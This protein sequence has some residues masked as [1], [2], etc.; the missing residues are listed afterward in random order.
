MR[1]PLAELLSG[2]PWPR[3]SGARRLIKGLDACLPVQHTWDTSL[4][5]QQLVAHREHRAIH[6]AVFQT[7][8]GPP[9]AHQ[10][11][12][13]LEPGFVGSSP[14]EPAT[15]T[16]TLPV[17]SPLLCTQSTYGAAPTVLLVNVLR[18]NEADTSLLNSTYTALASL[19]PPLF[20]N[21]LPVMLT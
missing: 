12:V 6:A 20:S 10:G 4:E 2:A 17:V 3:Q 8:G 7:A 5:S 14:L 9:R 16:D 15:D 11:A 18:V 19:S 13:L 1:A 21:T